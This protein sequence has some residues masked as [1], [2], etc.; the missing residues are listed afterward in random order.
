MPDVENGI[1]QSRGHVPRVRGRWSDAIE[2]DESGVNYDDA[3]RRLEEALNG[4]LPGEAAQ[5]R[6]APRPRRQWPQGFNPA[7]VRN[8]A[9]LLLIYRGQALAWPGPGPGLAPLARNERGAR[10]LLTV[11]ADALR[12]GGQISLPGGVVDPGETFEQTALREARE[13]I[14]L[15]PDG[16]RVLGRLTPLD[17]PV[18]GFRLH[19]IVAARS[20]LPALAAHHGEVAAILEIDLDDLTDPAVLV[21][22][23][24]VRDGVALTVPAFLVGG[25]EIWGATAMVLAEFLTLLGWTPRNAM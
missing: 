7:R 22:R 4:A 5:A 21:E 25:R 17:I 8:A 20:S 24:R 6:L 13:E 19:P 16:V 18:S 2:R 15:M 3:V 23:A 10:I 14:G 9:G 11:R 12:H 1:A